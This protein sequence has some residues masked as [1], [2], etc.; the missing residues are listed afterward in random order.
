MMADIRILQEQS[1]QLQNLIGADR[2]AERSDQGGQRAPRRADRTPTARRSPIRSWSSTRWPTICACCARRSTTT[3][4]ASDRSARKSTRCGSRCRDERAAAVRRRADGGDAA[5]A[6]GTPPDADAPPAAAGAAG[7]GASP[8]KLLD[9]ALA[10][11]YAGQYDLRDPG[12]RV[13][14]QDVPAVAAGARRAGAR[15]QLVPAERA[16]TTRRSRRTT[17]SSAPIRRATR[18]PRRTAKKGMA[19][20][21]PEAVRPGPRSARVR[22]QELPGQRW[23]RRSRSSD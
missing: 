19:L 2:D 22:R 20:H 11:Y 18:S 12:L 4:C 3:T 16:R 21:E 10:D 9:G 1:Q 15:R 8:Q 6:G 7:V 13:L 14:H 5:A 17:S 23:R